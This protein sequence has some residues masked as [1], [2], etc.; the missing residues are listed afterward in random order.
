M[1]RE[2]VSWTTM[3]CEEHHTHWA[4]GWVDGLCD[5]ESIAVARITKSV[6]DLATICNTTGR[7]SRP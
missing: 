5:Q 4:V 7:L 6:S 3:F 2:A 1:R